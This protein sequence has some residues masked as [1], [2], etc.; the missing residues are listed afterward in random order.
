M[1]PSCRGIESS[2]LTSKASELSWSAAILRR[3][4]I[5]EQSVCR[6]KSGDESPHSKNAPSLSK[7]KARKIRAFFILEREGFEPSIP[8]R[9]MRP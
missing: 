8:F 3:F 6:L 9:G 2:N 1:S 4:F 5:A 7:K